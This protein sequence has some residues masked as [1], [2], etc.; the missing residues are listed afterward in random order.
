ML[1]R[2]C[3]NR[4][5]GL[6]YLA[7]FL[8]LSVLTVL[9]RDARISFTPFSSEDGLSQNHVYCILQDKRGFLWFG[10]RDGLN[11]FDGYHFKVYRYD[12]DDPNSIS[13]HYVYDLFEDHQGFLWAATRN[14]LNK[15]DPKQD[16]F[17]RYQ[18]DKNNPK[19]IS[20]GNITD[21]AGD[22]GRFLWV[23][24]M[25][26][27]LNF[28]NG[29][30]NQFTHYRHDPES[31]EGL[32]SDAVWRIKSDE[33]GILWVG[34]LDNGLNRFNPENGRF[35]VIGHNPQDVNSLIDNEIWCLELGRNDVL[36]IGNYGGLVR[37][38]RK[39][40]AMRRFLP[41]D[42]PKTLSRGRVQSI[43]EDSAGRIWIG[44][45][46]GGLNLLDETTGHF[47]HYSHGP[48]DP[49]SISHNSI[50]SLFE[51]STGLL[52]AGTFGGGV[53]RFM[54]S[55]DPFGH[56]QYNGSSTGLSHNQV[57]SFQEDPDNPDVIWTGTFR[58]LDRFNS[59]SGE[60]SHYRH[61]PSDVNSLTDD[62]VLCIT[63]DSSGLLWVGAFE[64]L[65][66]VE[67]E[68]GRVTRFQR[69]TGGEN[70]LS[71]NEVRTIHLDGRGHLW[72]GV[73]AGGLNR[74]ELARPGHFTHF[75]P[76]PR[77]PNSLGHLSVL[78]VIG[79]GGDGLFVG[80]WGSGLNHLL[81]V[82]ST[83]ESAHFVHY[84]N[85]PNNPESLSNDIVYS[86]LRDSGGTLW[87]GTSGG[88]N[89]KQFEEGGA[90]FV[91]YHMRDGLPNEVIYGILEDD[92]GYLWL[93]TNKGLARFNPKTENIRAFDP[94]DGVQSNEFK[95][96]AAFRDS[97]GRLY[98]GG[99]NGF[100]VFKPG[101]IKE[102][103][104]PPLMVLTDLYLANKPVHGPDHP[105]ILGGTSI[106]WAETMVLSHDQNIF[107][108]QFAALHYA[109]PE[110]NRYR[111]QLNPFNEDWVETHDGQHTATYT[112]LDPGSYYFHV[113][114]SNKDGVWNET[115]AGI[116]IRILPPI[117]QTWWAYSFYLLALAGCFLA[118]VFAQK[119]KLNFQTA[120]NERLKHLD[121]LKDQF[122]ANTSH[123]LRTPLNGIVGVAESMM[124][125]VSGRINKKMA[126][127]LRMVITSG[128]RL[129]SLVDDI[130]D[131][132]LMKKQELVLHRDA[133][134]LKILVDEIF[135]FS[136][137]LIEPES[138]ELINAIP[139]DIGGVDADENRL[140]QILH[141]LIGNAV[142]FT[143]QGWIKAEATIQDGFL[144]V[145]IS[146]TGRGIKQDQLGRIF[147]SFVQGEGGD[148][149]K[150]GGTGLGLAI[151]RR[152]VTLHGGVIKVTSQPGEGS[153]FT[154]T[155]PRAQ[156]DG[157]KETHPMP[158]RES[159][160][161]V[162]DPTDLKDL[163]VFPF[164]EE[165]P[166]DFNILVVDDDRVN[167]RV[168][169]NHL[170]LRKYQV[171]ESK[172]GRDALETL[173][174]DGPF[175]LLLL[176]VMMPGMSGYEVCRKIRETHPVHDLPIIFLTA[177]GQTEDLVEGFDAG[178]ND[179]LT[180][181]VAKKELLSRVRTHLQLLD[182]TRHLESRVVE[183]THELQRK[184]DE[185]TVLDS[186][187]KTL[188]QEIDLSGVL[189][190]M[191]DQGL[192]LFPHA[193]KSAFFLWN[194]RRRC[195]TL[196]AYTGHQPSQFQ[197][198]TFT[199]S[200]LA[201]RYEGG[202]DLGDGMFHLKKKDLRPIPELGNL[203]AP[204]SLIATFLTTEGR[205]QG[206]LIFENFHDPDAFANQDL[207]MLRRF[208]GHAVTALAKARTLKDLAETQK[209]LLEAAHTAGMAEI[210][211][212]V[213]HN[214]GNILNSVKASGQQIR[215]GL[216]SRAMSLLEKISN[217]LES[218]EERRN[219][220][221]S[222]E[223]RE[224]LNDAIHR[225]WKGLKEQRDKLDDESGRL[226]LHVDAIAEVLRE[227][228]EYAHMERTLQEPTDINHLIEDILQLKAYLLEEKQIAI[229]K[230]YGK[231]PLLSLRK[232][233]MKHVF[234]Y[235]F[236]N[237][238]EA[239]AEKATQEGEIHITT[240][241]NGEKLWV[242]IKDNGVGI[243]PELIPRVFVQ[244]YTTKKGCRGFG[245]HYCANTLSELSGNIDINSEGPGQGVTVTL[246]LPI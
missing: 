241:S 62:Q 197:K 14:G 113:Q 78:T 181:P 20:G 33:S 234:H 214:V 204:S 80:T 49:A 32:S 81:S 92:Q 101:D 74:M 52:W 222:E 186:I 109:A 9:G 26:N 6:S 70:S 107:S 54:G 169:T 202:E 177:R 141:N 73:V 27:G 47:S 226:L 120:M 46:G 117:W 8:F 2:I 65:N 4:V 239:I 161:F 175:D 176:D 16:R 183:R 216:D 215:D 165:S 43:L 243:S 187:V 210:A 218:E 63:P 100:N 230:H 229:I 1:M 154:F 157:R 153:V 213:L 131:F 170:S 29:E 15:Y 57:T 192:T 89:R 228:R 22:G 56:F 45:M 190:A 130:L 136:V 178:G 69:E 85:D 39:T 203:A 119:R 55:G 160:P 87:V 35:D 163:T 173:E 41:D 231:L 233:Q 13:N 58:G 79:D 149:R 105:D 110:K 196:A 17:T 172:N 108:L 19:A 134:D 64:G 111:Y 209:D 199:E 53:N 135:K 82:S 126:D 221:T 133:V 30:T 96:G 179:Y 67:R 164:S 156:G 236:N 11:R 244:G 99:V 145:S 60:F 220:A 212:D 217:I 112:Q 147:E 116:H 104:H 122:L 143:E 224:K 42:D 188:N 232:A 185:L 125:G 151:T 191:L 240:H 77:L 3:R 139:E 97:R 242:Q 194:K 184:Y 200:Q 91:S 206:I 103:I 180:K 201:A 171:A 50:W 31:K 137:P 25:S 121:R 118:F 95:P 66:R 28:L 207:A 208:R 227:Q 86:L 152:L 5:Q 142:K 144:A 21:I 148:A 193:E 40:G 23:G 84:Y 10:T 61:N 174:R 219:F 114:G 146:D 189:Q 225:I 93:S 198:L 90:S 94:Y 238:W 162:E 7:I 167:R 182:V 205:R 140:R 155:L 18:P 246:T 12:S 34:T 159:A 223:A 245:L 59:Q 138:V 44:T 72:A 76:D 235:L 127:N 129:A 98:F 166:G 123:E 48:G 106:E 75:K 88:L 158:E 71:H 237:A 68:T 124:D 102:D 128:K 83:P 36:W 211:T 195:Y 132:S 38:N 150:F 168:L 37:L 115:G 24:T 51:D